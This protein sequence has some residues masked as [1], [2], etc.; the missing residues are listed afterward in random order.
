[1]LPVY[2]ESR[3]FIGYLYFRSFDG[4]LDCQCFFFGCKG[5]RLLPGTN[6]IT[7]ANMPEVRLKKW[8]R[9]NLHIANMRYEGNVG[10]IK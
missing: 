10:V 3:V 4:E 8:K 6:I 5:E 2:N 9:G 1:M 7:L